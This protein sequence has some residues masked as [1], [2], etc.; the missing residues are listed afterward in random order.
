MDGGRWIERRRT[1]PN[2]ETPVLK[3]LP[4]SQ[5]VPRLAGDGWVSSMTGD[6]RTEVSVQ[7]RGLLQAES[8]HTIRGGAGWE[9]EVRGASLEGGGEA[10]M[11]ESCRLWSSLYV[12]HPFVSS[13]LLVSFPTLFSFSSFASTFSFSSF[14]VYVLSLSVVSSSFS[15]SIP[16]T[17]WPDPRG[18][19]AGDEMARDAEG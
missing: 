5:H 15:L 9:S 8:I 3:P 18:A 6:I 12:F 10:R 17:R 11:G 13:L 16:Q 7:G 1:K 19:V 2:R 4:E 14:E